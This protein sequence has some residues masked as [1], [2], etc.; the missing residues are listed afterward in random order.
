M[1]F[2]FTAHTENQLVLQKQLLPRAVRSGYIAESELL[3]FSSHPMDSPRGQWSLYQQALSSSRLHGRRKS[4]TLYQCMQ[5][6]EVHSSHGEWWNSQYP[7]VF[8]HLVPRTHC[9]HCFTCSWVHTKLLSRHLPRRLSKTWQAE[10]L[11]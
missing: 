11:P 10:P 5:V 4:C 3:L 6:R 1:V 8:P 9:S 7:G 2:L